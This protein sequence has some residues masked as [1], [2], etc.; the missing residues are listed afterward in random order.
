LT[1]FAWRNRAGLPATSKRRT[2]ITVHAVKSGN[3]AAQLPRASISK[4]GCR[5]VHM[6]TFIV[7][8]HFSEQGIRNVKE[9]TKRAD[10]FKEQAQRLGGSVKEIYWTMGRYDIVSI[11]EAPDEKA[12][13]ALGLTIGKLGNVRTE[14]LRAFS[15]ADMDGILSKVA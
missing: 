11:V 12:I 7:L 15:K 10:A 13:T 5:E 6:A 2:L 14:T 8:T 1:P 9:T 4:P 3:V